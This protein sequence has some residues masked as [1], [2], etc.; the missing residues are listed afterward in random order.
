MPLYRKRPEVVE[1]F[2]LERGA[3]VQNSRDTQY[4]NPGDYVVRTLDGEL[5][6]IRQDVFEK[7]YEPVDDC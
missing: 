6:V 2:Q 1:A 5:E 3:V 4:G 7:M